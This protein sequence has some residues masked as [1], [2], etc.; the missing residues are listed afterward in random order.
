M[1][2]LTEAELAELV[3]T[4]GLGAL[5]DWA[6]IEAG[7]INSNY[8]V[9]AGAIR[10]FVRVNEGKTAADI[11]Y[12]VALVDA[13]RAAGVRTP[14]ILSTPA[15]E[16][17][18]WRLDRPVMLFEWIDGA[19]RSPGEITATDV[20]EVAASLSGLH[21]ATESFGLRRDGIYRTPDI[22]RRFAG[23]S[24]SSDPEL[25]DAIAVIAEELDF[26]DRHAAV[27]SALPRAVIHQDLF[28]DNVL[29]SDGELPPVLI[30]FEQA[31]DGARLYDLAVLINS[32]CFG[33]DLELE[34][35]RLAAAVAG[36]GPPVE[37]EALWI[38]LRAGAVRFAV[39]RITDVYLAGLD[40]SQKDFRDYLDRL[41]LWRQIGID[42]LAGRLIDVN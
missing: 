14:A 40:R 5:D 21:R 36:F 6:R 3:E 22:A 13:I 26:L 25:A 17:A 33:V 16:R 15:G 20:G 42:G 9:D 41:G 28:P 29:W 32:W 10:A 18:V 38:E 23:F 2:E 12:E 37:P 11:D 34:T 31:A 7:T 8:R 19:H 24:G 4:F 30:D 35:D 27:R 1:T 39:T